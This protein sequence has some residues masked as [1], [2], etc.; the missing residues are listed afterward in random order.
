MVQTDKNKSIYVN[1]AQ[2]KVTTLSGLAKMGTELTTVHGHCITSSP[3]YKE[4]IFF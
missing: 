2:V 4:E 1:I 3:K